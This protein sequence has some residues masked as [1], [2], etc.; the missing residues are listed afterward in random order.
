MLNLSKLHWGHK[1]Y[2]AGLEKRKRLGL[3]GK[4]CAF[5]D[6]EIEITHR[7]FLNEINNRNM[8]LLS[9]KI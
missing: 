1:S 5:P 9:I 6:F 8:S 4:A 3:V 2:I 7:M